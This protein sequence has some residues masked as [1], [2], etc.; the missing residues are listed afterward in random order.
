MTAK[1]MQIFDYAKCTLILFRLEYQRF[2]T[3]RVTTWL[4]RAAK[5]HPSEL[6]RK[7]HH[8][9]ARVGVSVCCPISISPLKRI[10]AM[11]AH[12]IRRL[13]L[14]CLWFLKYSNHN[15]EQNPKYMVK[16]STLSMLV[17]SLSGVSGGLKNERNRMIP[18]ISMDRGY[19]FR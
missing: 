14:P 5:I 13:V 18:I 11:I 2:N 1:I 8:S 15:T 4:N 12:R 19:F 9:A 16:C 6:K 10:G 7:S 17:T 3:R